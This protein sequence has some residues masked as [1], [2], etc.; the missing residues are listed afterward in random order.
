MPLIRWEPLTTEV[1]NVR[2]EIARMFYN[3]APHTEEAIKDFTLLPAAELEEMP[4]AILVR[5]ELPGMEAKDFDIEVTATTVSIS[6]ERKSESKT[7]KNGNMRTEFHYGRFERILSLPA[8]VEN[9][10]AK[11]EYKD[12]ILSLILPKAKEQKSVATKVQLG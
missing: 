11:A 7:E 1:E 5:L 8:Q 10:Q 12:G 9:E 3:F 4:D 6:G 2:R